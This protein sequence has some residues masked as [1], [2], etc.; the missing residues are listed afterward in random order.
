MKRISGFKQ[1]R[2]I[3]KKLCISSKVARNLALRQLLE[4]ALFS[5]DAVLFGAKPKQEEEPAES[6]KDLITENKKIVSN[7]FYSKLSKL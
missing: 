4:R 6:N 1:S 2:S 7:K 3:L 5:K